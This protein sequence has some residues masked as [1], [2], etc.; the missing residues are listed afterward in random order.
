M[1]K[2]KR[3]KSIVLKEV[4]STNDYAKAR[5]EFG[6]DII[7]TAKRQTGGRGTKGRSFVSDEGGVYLSALRF[8]ENYPAK[9]AFEEMASAAV[10]VCKTL[11]SYGVKPVI[12]WANDVHVNGK[13]I[14]GILVENTFSGENIRCSVTGI[15]VNVN[16]R[17][18]DELRGIATT[19]R[20]EIGK[21]VSV[22]GVTRRLKAHLQERYPVEEYL[23]RLGYMGR[24][25]ELNFGDE[26]VPA[27]LLCVDN[28]G[29]LWAEVN[30]EKRGFVAAEVSVI[31]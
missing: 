3:I 16:N 27:T 10:A 22:G 9:R 5:R 23:E 24:S 8:Y 18:P 29:K 17:L 6:E 2:K 7:V 28:E 14:C 30:G 11:E 25:V 1:N 26:R 4:A 19:L 21:K 12:K 13:K 20:E 31:L 15:G